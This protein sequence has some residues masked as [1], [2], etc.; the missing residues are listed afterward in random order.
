ML[1]CFNFLLWNA[2]FHAAMLLVVPRSMI[3]YDAKD[4]FAS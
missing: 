1:C 3:F 2:V 4:F